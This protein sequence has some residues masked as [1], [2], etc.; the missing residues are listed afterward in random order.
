MKDKDYLTDEDINNISPVIAHKEVP[1]EIT[2]TLGTRFTGTTRTTH[3]G[4]TTTKY[5]IT[6]PHCLNGDNDYN[7]I[8]P[9]GVEVNSSTH[10]SDI[11]SK[12]DYIKFHLECENCGSYFVLLCGKGNYGFE[13]TFTKLES[14]I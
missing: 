4:K 8:W 6:C 12:G 1:L 14:K 3:F 2:H 10:K 9:R 13:M 5:E 7:Q 11:D